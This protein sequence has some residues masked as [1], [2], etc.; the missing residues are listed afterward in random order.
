MHKRILD[1]LA[2]GSTTVLADL[3]W[4]LMKEI[5]KESI[6]EE[7][8]AVAAQVRLILKPIFE[9]VLG[10]VWEVVSFIYHMIP[11]TIMATISITLIVACI[12]NHAVT[13]VRPF[14][15][16]LSYCC[17]ANPSASPH[18]PFLPISLNDITHALSCNLLL[19]NQTNHISLLYS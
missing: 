19:R 5:L 3:T 17:L 6:V 10:P 18:L 9:P 16:Y 2:L 1:L 12:I 8:E 14:L 11:K 15:L 13:T 7:I 4:D